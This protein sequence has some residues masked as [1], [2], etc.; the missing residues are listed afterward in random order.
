M[1][2]AVKQ[3][4]V[5]L[6]YLRIRHGAGV[7]HSKRT[8]DFVLPLLLSAATCAYFVWLSI[9]FA[10]F[11]H[12][13]LVKRLSDL[14]SLM[15]VFYMA[16][17]AAVATFDR[18]GIDEEMEGDPA[19][20][21]VREPNGAQKVDKVLSYRQFISYLFGYLSFLSLL[22]YVFIM[23][24]DVGW[25]RLEL[26][27]QDSPLIYCVL[28]RYFDPVIAFVLFAAI[29]QLIITSLLGIYF[30]TE[31]IQTLNTPGD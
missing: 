24:S 19:V 18:K 10:I 2:W 29:W 20:L 22:L 11:D 1:W 6:N 12:P 28:T 31:R 15:I 3:L 13:A 26:H 30:L 4:S 8:Y 17:L 5:P 9:S 27:F 21:R 14:L 16:A 25:K 23:V 7:F